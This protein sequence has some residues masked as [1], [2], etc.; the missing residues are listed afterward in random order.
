ME[1]VALAA[2]LV[3]AAA[4]A[5]ALVVTL[6]VPLVATLALAVAKADGV[7][8]DDLRT[9]PCEEQQSGCVFQTAEKR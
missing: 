2:T 4:L 8:D 7:G 1:L 9:Y 3:L 5:A 6:H